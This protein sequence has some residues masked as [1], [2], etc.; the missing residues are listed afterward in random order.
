MTGNP[1]LGP[2]ISFLLGICE[3]IKYLDIKYESFLFE[4]FENDNELFNN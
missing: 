4:I 3:L 1:A 2:K